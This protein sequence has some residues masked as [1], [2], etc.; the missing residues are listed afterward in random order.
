M[1]E[2][3]GIAWALNA[4][5]SVEVVATGQTGPGA[6]A[7]WHGRQA[8]QDWTGW[9]PLG[10]PA[11]GVLGCAPAVACN[12]GGRIEI[13]AIGNDL[14]LWHAWERQSGQDWTGWHPLGQP[15]G[16]AVV[17]KNV[18]ARPPAPTPALVANFNGSL[19]AFVVRTDHSV[20]HRGQRH[21]G[22]WSDWAPLGRPGSGTM[23]PLSVSDNS[24][25]NL[26]LFV[27]DVDGVVW[28]LA[29]QDSGGWSS[30]ESLGIPGGLS[31]RNGLATVRGVDGRPEVFAVGSGHGVLW[32]RCQQPA[33]GWSDWKSLDS[34]GSGFADIA[35][36]PDLTARL[37][38]FATEQS[39]SSALWQRTQTSPG[40]DWGP[41]QSRSD[42]LLSGL[43]GPGPSLEAPVLAWDANGMLR[44]FVQGT[45]TGD[46]Y[47]LIQVGDDPAAPDAWISKMTR[48]THS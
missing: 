23:G 21:P 13:A 44:L 12:T 16:K 11:G 19:E 39:S 25:G 1:S 28:H 45:G 9:A 3:R 38:L 2:L 29:Q 4:D 37:V 40:G 33:G 22:G 41:W 34:Q 10:G 8:S 27:N 15:G 35:V 24:D 17:S 14:A 5:G 48:L 43:P 46:M 20:W 31:A 7:I 18:G 36:A 26:E 6:C 32:H 42:L 30:W 47:E